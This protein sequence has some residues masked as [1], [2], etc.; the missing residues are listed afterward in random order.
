MS[1]EM[2]AVLD[3]N[4]RH[5][6]RVASRR[7]VHLD[8]LWHAGMHLCVTDGQGHV[9]QQ[10]RSGGPQMKVLPDVWDLFF[11]A[12]HVRAHE[13]PL[14]TLLRELAA[15]VGIDFTVE[16]LHD[17]MR[18]TKVSVTKSEYWVKDGSFPPPFDKAEGS[19]GGFWHRVYDHNYVACMPDL[20]ISKLTLDSRKVVEVR[21]YPID[22]LFRDVEDP[23]NPA[24]SML[25]H[26]PPDDDKLY[27][28][29]LKEAQALTAA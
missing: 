8:G 1:R 17:D 16:R 15:E 9:F 3:E 19:D 6:G 11:I 28:H 27:D 25:A 14:D 12:G 22:Q 20:D 7:E 4:G 23:D 21:R 18:L 26:R 2:F 13:E 24:Y 10:L 5:T 29:V